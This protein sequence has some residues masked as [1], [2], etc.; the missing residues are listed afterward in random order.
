[1]DIDPKK[2]RLYP[3][4]CAAAILIGVAAPP[5][6]AFAS[7]PENEGMNV[8]VVVDS[9]K[10]MLT[11][12]PNELRKSA[13]KLLLAMLTSKDRA[14]IVSFSGDGYLLAE[15]TNMDTPEERKIVYQAVDKL[16]SKGNFTNFSGAL[17]I[18]KSALDSSQNETGKSIVIFITDGKINLDAAKKNQQLTETLTNEL[19]PWFSDRKIP[20]QTIALTDKADQELL[21]KISSD[22]G[23]IYSYAHSAEELHSIFKQITDSSKNLFTISIVKNRFRVL[24]RYKSIRIYHEIDPAGSAL[25]LI[26]PSGVHFS[27]QDKLSET[28]WLQ[29]PS[30]DVISFTDWETGEWQIN[31]LNNSTQIYTFTQPVNIPGTNNGSDVATIVK[32]TESIPANHAIL[33]QKNAPSSTLSNAE[34]PVGHEAIIQYMTSEENKEAMLDAVKI[35]A[36][37]NGSFILLLLL[38]RFVR[39]IARKRKMSGEVQANFNKPVILDQLVKENSI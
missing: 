11:S 6:C 27:R 34:N 23:G 18:V 38:H 39:R 32:D 28:E 14:G 8:F 9:S 25:S 1:M 10:S 21:K 13:I 3:F 19:I 24:P 17:D 4:L 31:K 29:T 37:I 20:I 5:F 16:S 12:D 35:F 7:K 22:T 26:S 30:F 15:L 2:I 33:N 36:A